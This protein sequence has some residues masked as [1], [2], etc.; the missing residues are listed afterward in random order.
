MDKWIKIEDRKPPNDVYVLVSIY[1]G[2][3]KVQM[4]FIRICSRFNDAWVDDHDGEIISS[5]YGRVTHWMP[6]PDKPEKEYFA[7][8]KNENVS[9]VC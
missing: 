6:L 3:P 1:D 9:C 7:E 5:K 8:C 4:Y 2:R